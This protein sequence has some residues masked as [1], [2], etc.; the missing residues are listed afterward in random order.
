MLLSD[1][2]SGTISVAANGTAVT[3]VG[4]GW[5]AAGFQEG[6]LLFANGYSGVVLSV[7]SN[8]ALTL[9][10]PWRGGALSGAAYRLRY[11][12]DGSRFSAQAR[13]LIEMIG[14]SGNL[15]A[16][17]GLQGAANMLAYFTGAGQM[18]VTALTAFARTLLDDPDASALLSTLG[19]SAFAKTLLDD[20]NAAAA[21]ATLGL[22]IGTDV[23]AQNAA[24]SSIAGLTTVADQMIYT[25][26][27]NAY[28]T[29]ALTPFARTILD[30]VDAAAVRGT[31]ELGSAAVKNTG[32]SGDAVPLLNAANTWSQTQR[33]TSA[34]TRVENLASALPPAG[35]HNSAIFTALLPNRQARQAFFGVRE[36]NWSMNGMIAVFDPSANPQWRN[37]YFRQDGNAYAESGSWVNSSDRRLKENITPI[38]D[39]LAALDKLSG[40]TWTRRDTGSFGVGIIAQDA[41]EAVPG[42][43]MVTGNSIL[44]DGTVIEN[45]LAIDTAGVGVAVL[46]EAVKAMRDQV[47][48]LQARVDQLEAAAG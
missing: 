22:T 26:A 3:G 42:S 36:F 35:G 12:S 15:E 32:T 37:W 11:Q 10:Q 7:G 5:A 39:P 20:A 40:C 23:Q 41:E 1:Y 28:A 34:E 48:A 8:T 43:A 9:A 30:D 25:T 47:V 29:T 17:G 31:L 46:V 2:T 33:V 16:L 4:T 44:S 21:R 6:D 14:G 13:A 38:P 18:D 27:A 24:L 19:V 45:A